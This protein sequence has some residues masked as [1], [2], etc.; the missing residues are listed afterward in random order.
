M[1]LPWSKSFYRPPEAPKLPE[2]KA[3][4]EVKA[5]VT[6]ETTAAPEP[7]VI[8]E[9]VKETVVVKEVTPPAPAVKEEAPVKE[10]P[11]KEAMEQETKAPAPTENP[12][13]IIKAID[14]KINEVPAGSWQVQLMS[15][16]NKPAVESSWKNLVKN[17]RFWPARFMK[18][19]PQI[20]AKRHFLPLKA[21]A[22]RDRAEAD[23]LCNDIKALGGTCIVK[24][25]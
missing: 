14:A 20:S 7:A 9:T 13:A 24:K 21:G 1:K 8:Q 11:L 23:R 4:E 10:V 16:T 3:S 2:V 12:K 19:K 25:K 22:F 6:A 18:S 5:A 15:S 17:T